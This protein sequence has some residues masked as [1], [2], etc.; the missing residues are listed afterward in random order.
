M[1]FFNFNFYLL[2]I[3]LFIFLNW[4]CSEEPIQNDLSNI[5]LRIDTLL[6]DDIS[7]R[8]YW[9]APNL[10]TSDYL[11]LG[12]KNNI[13]ANYSFITFSNNY[14]WSGFLDSNIIFDSLLFILYAR[15]SLVEQPTLYYSPDSQF[16]EYESTYLDYTEFQM[17]EWINLGQPDIKINEDTTNIDSLDHFQYS[18]LKWDIINHFDALTDTSDSNIVRTF[19]LVSGNNNA[20]VSKI[21]SREGLPSYR[22]IIKT[23]H[24]LN[25]QINDDSTVIDTVSGQLLATGDLTIMEPTD[26]VQDSS[27]IG[28]SS[29]HGHQLILSINY[30][31]LSLPSRALL[32]SAVLTINLDTTTIIDD[33]SVFINPLNS[34]VDTFSFFFEED[35]YQGVGYPYLVSNSTENGILEI[36]LKR[37]LQNIS[38]GNENNLGFKVL[39]SPLNDPFE[40]IRFNLNNVINPASIK[41]LYVSNN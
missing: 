38:V 22:P 39:A 21:F 27:N 14:N 15:D 13:N 2:F 19:I 35:P 17:S 37:Y 4:N 30:D 32:R 26:I 1:Q 6:I 16:S 40:S 9:I 25:N 20:S 8:P 12:S 29:G 33:F 7:A 18:E 41:I 31:S 5:N 28:L 34:E 10:G 24:F 23:V 3:S 36:S 11:Y